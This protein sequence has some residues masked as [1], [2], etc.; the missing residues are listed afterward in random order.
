MGLVGLLSFYVLW[1]FAWSCEH[2]SWAVL[3]ITEHFHFEIKEKN[4]YSKAMLRTLKCSF[5]SH[6]LSL[7][8]CRAMFK[9]AG[10]S[11]W[12]EAINH[13]WKEEM[14]KTRTEFFLPL[15]LPQQLSFVS[16]RKNKSSIIFLFTMNAILGRRSK[17]WL[18]QLR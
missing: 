11:G 18:T 10:F 4:R 14:W 7:L 8:K 1:K 13:R 3:Y 16:L 5:R 2:S 17:K 12:S 6:S 9:F 15:L